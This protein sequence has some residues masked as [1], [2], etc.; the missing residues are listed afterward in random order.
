MVVPDAHKTRLFTFLIPSVWCWN[1]YYF[2]PD[3]AFYFFELTMVSLRQV[4]PIPNF[5]SFGDLKLKSKCNDLDCHDPMMFST[6]K[7]PKSLD[8]PMGPYLSNHSRYTL[9]E[10]CSRVEAFA[11]VLSPEFQIVECF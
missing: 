2:D 4:L 6:G 11:K 5:S 1:F 8:L 9:H 3:P 10:K 7:L